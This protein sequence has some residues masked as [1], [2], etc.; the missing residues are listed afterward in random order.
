MPTDELAGKRVMVTRPAHQAEHL[1]QLL[2]AEGAVPVLFPVLEIVEP[3]DAAPGLD[4]VA[5]LAEFDLAIFISPNAVSRALNLINA[6]GGLPPQL[7]LVTIGRGSARELRALTGRQPDIC[8]QGKFDSEGLL[9]LPEMHEVADKRIVIFRG[10]GGRELLGDTLRERGAKVEYANVYRRARPQP[11]VERLR[12]DWARHGMDFICVTSGE[13]LR[14]L[15]DMVGAL[16]QTWLRQTRL[17][18]V[19]ERLAQIARELGVVPSPIVAP[20]ASDE[21]MVEAIKSWLR[22]QDDSPR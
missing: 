5:R 10:E 16:V 7:T 6:R 12:R 22:A 19:N 21:A 13:G 2:Q 1:C 8:P 14:N 15:F 17:V 3:E 4:V 18:L 9:A 20:D 11:D